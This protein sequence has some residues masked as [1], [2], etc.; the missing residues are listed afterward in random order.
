MTLPFTLPRLTGKRLM[1]VVIIV[2]AVVTALAAVVPSGPLER[3]SRLWD[4][5]AQAFDTRQEL[6]AAG[7]EVWTESP[8]NVQRLPG[9]LLLVLR[10]AV[11][12]FGRSA[13]GRHISYPW[14]GSTN[15]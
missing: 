6:W 2:L 1:I 14:I 12:E 10:D 8:L 4:A 9:I 7:F 3:I 5:P 11:T 13:L 15:V